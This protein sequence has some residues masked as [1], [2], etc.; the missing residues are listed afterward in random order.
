M[1][2]DWFSNNQKCLHSRLHSALALFAVGAS[3]HRPK[4]IQVVCTLGSHCLHIKTRSHWTI[5]NGVNETRDGQVG[6]FTT[7]PVSRLKISKK[8]EKVYTIDIHKIVYIRVNN[9]NIIDIF[10]I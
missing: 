3:D 5:T 4:Q 1:N 6:A 9:V 7:P 2:N 10:M 8:L